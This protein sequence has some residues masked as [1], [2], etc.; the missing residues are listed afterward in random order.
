MGDEVTEALSLGEA[1]RCMWRERRELIN[2]PCESCDDQNVPLPGPQADALGLHRAMH[3]VGRE[4]LR[5]L[6]RA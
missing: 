5:V 3:E 4:M 6:F 1:L 2:R